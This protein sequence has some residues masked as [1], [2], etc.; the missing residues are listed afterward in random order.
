MTAFIVIAMVMLV[1]LG[2]ESALI[3]DIA[4]LAACVVVSY[5]A[6]KFVIEDSKEDRR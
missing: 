5:Y 4:I 1:G 2:I 6:I 3:I